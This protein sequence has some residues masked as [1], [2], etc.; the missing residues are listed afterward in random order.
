MLSGWE[1]SDGLG[2]EKLK[3]T[4]HSDWLRHQHAVEFFPPKPYTLDPELCCTIFTKA[5]NFRKYREDMNIRAKEY[6]NV[7]YVMIMPQL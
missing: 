2:E 6:N 1:T 5:S 3:T 7:I 4:V